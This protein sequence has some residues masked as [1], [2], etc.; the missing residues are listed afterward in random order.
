[1]CFSDQ[2]GLP[3]SFGETEVHMCKLERLL[4]SVQ[5]SKS[6]CLAL[7]CGPKWRGRVNCS[8]LVTSER[9]AA[10]EL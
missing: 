2:I 3:L 1:M 9:A 4:E 5:E 6:S 7:F 10:V 8:A